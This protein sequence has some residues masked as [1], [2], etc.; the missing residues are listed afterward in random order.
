MRLVD[1]GTGQKTRLFPKSLGDEW[2]E[3]VKNLLS[4]SNEWVRL[5]AA[6][7]LLTATTRK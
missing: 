6:T 4:D 5:R 3:R 1:H 2:L 7:A